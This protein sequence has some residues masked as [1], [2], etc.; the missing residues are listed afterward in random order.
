VKDTIEHYLSC[1]LD[2]ALCSSSN[3]IY[4][5]KRAELCDLISSILALESRM[6][7]LEGIEIQLTDL[8]QSQI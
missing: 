1:E 7:P 2:C 5:L 4:S 6:S 3:F 8:A